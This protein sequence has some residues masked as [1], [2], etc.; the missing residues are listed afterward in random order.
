MGYPWEAMVV[1]F[2]GVEDLQEGGADLW[3]EVVL[4]L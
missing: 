4:D 2:M 3:E 1:L